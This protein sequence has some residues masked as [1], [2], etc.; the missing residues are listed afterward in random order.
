MPGSRR[1]PGSGALRA[2]A[3]GTISFSFVKILCVF[4]L[5][6]LMDFGRFCVD[7]APCSSIV[8]HNYGFSLILRPAQFFY[9]NTIGFEAVGRA[10]RLPGL[11]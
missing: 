9:R 10:S 7:F 11:R 3:P 4:S 5:D 2:P 1:L 8:D 6:L